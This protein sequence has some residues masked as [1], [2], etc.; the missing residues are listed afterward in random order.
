MLTK[1]NTKI[2]PEQRELIENAQRRTKQKKGL[3]RHFVVFL[4]GAIILII[5]N[6]GLDFGKDFRPFNADWF[7]WAILLWLFFLL[8]HTFN[9]F[10]TNKFL[11]KE[12]EERQLEILVEKQ[13]KRIAELKT[14]VEKDYPLPP[15][16]KNDPEPLNPPKPFNS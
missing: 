1:Q 2:D 11:N 15:N 4:V 5:V 3:F 9:V 8:I 7:V 10:V 6:V 13:Q 14:Q 16:P 12:W